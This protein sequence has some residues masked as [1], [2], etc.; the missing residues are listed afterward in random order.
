MCAAI[1]ILGCGFAF[2]QIQ[3]KVLYNF[4][5]LDGQDPVTGLTF[6]TAG[7]LYGTTYGGGA[8]DWGT[9]FEL[10]PGSDGTWTESVLYSFAE[11]DGLPIGGLTFDAKGNLYGTTFYGGFVF[12]L[13]PNIDGTWTETTIFQ[14]SDEFH[15][16]FASPVVFDNQGNLYL[17]SGTG[18]NT[19]CNV[20]GC[21]YIL[22]LSPNPDGTWTESTVYTFTGGTGGAYPVGITFDSSG[23]LYGLTLG[24]GTGC[25]TGCGTA[26][27]LTPNSD[28]TWTPSLLHDIPPACN[29]DCGPVGAP[30]LDN[31]GNL[32]GATSTFVFQLS[33]TPKGPWKYAKVKDFPSEYGAQLNPL[34][35]SNGSVYGTNYYG[36][37]VGLGSV[38]QISY[39]NG[40]KSYGE[41]QFADEGSYGAHPRCAVIAD[42]AGNLYGTT[43][44]GGT[45]YDGVVFELSK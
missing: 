5:G 24:G 31:A 23:N 34:Y 19:G 20:Q 45:F 2:G 25:G 33:P 21:G 11:N 6:D 43:E 27:K 26:F 8:N 15:G 14:L 29:G 35:F 40:R 32:Y 42:S 38:Y 41:F 39:S 22:E 16:S 4:S 1:A 3:E 9:V 10:T 30:V 28:G 7:N 44:E 13:S 37:N 12:E 18:G 36:G 17:A